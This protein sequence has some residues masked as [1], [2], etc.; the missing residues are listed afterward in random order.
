MTTPIFLRVYYVYNISIN[1]IHRKW[2]WTFELY[3]L[4]SV[5][6]V[7]RPT[8]EWQELRQVSNEPLNDFSTV[9]CQE[10]FGFRASTWI[11]YRMYCLYMYFCFSDWRRDS[12][13]IVPGTE[14]RLVRWAYR[15]RRLWQ[16]PKLPKPAW[17]EVDSDG[18]KTRLRLLPASLPIVLRLIHTADSVCIGR[19]LR[20]GQKTTYWHPISCR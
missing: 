20:R 14:L 13:T 5:Y 2:R 3:K 16:L 17:L 12:F 11:N 9:F 6:T 4:L 10:Y 19:S 18:L 8:I 15:L 7:Y 1:E